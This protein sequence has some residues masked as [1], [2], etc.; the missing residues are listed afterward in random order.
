MGRESPKD[1]KGFGKPLGSGSVFYLV[2]HAH[3]GWT[4]DEN[5]PLS[6]RGR[7]DAERVADVL[8][9]FPIAAIYSSPARRAWETFAPLAARLGL[10]IHVVPDLRE[11]KLCDG[12]VDDFFAAVRATWA[13]PS[14]AHPGGEPN[15]AAQRRGVAAVQRLME[16]HPTDHVVLGT[17]GNLLALVLQHFDAGVDFAFWRSLTMPDVYE[18]QVGMDGDASVR[19]LWE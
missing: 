12:A 6:G 1:P 15:A 8:G 10:P 9:G 4:P 7:A 3:A 18:L 13:D 16:R 5:R 11:H 17:H 2:R 19:R 14:L